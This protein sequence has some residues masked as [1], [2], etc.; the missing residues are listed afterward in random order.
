MAQNIIVLF[1]NPIEGKVKTRLGATI[2]DEKALM[3]YLELLEHTFK[4]ARAVQGT[5][6]HLFFS[7][8][9]DSRLQHI[10]A[11]DELYLQVKG[12]LG[13]KINHAFETVHQEGDKTIIIGSDC[14]GISTDLIQQAFT[15]L[16]NF[17]I[18]LGPAEDGGY[19][20][21]GLNE[22]DS[23]L[24]EG[25]SWSTDQVLKQTYQ[26]AIQAEKSVKLL[27]SLSDI[28]TEDDLHLLDE[29]I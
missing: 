22:K 4:V 6:L 18:V 2:G 1:K 23:S 10:G 21:L 16:D 9:I 11:E 17:S 28:D 20:L 27:I 3:V 8:F 14:P 15:V 12:S 13:E 29:Y 25:I 5:Y 7:D 19:Y 26:K 24:F